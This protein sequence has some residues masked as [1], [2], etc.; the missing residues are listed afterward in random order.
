RA[1]VRAG[2]ALRKLG[3]L[4]EARRSFEDAIA[5]I[6]RLAA[7]A[8]MNPEARG[9]L[10]DSPSAWTGLA[11]TLAKQGNAAG[12]LSAAEARLAHIRRVQLAAFQ[13]D[14]T[15]GETPDEQA[16]EQGVVRDII[17][18][19][20]QLRAERGMAHPDA[21]RLDTLQQQLAR[22]VARRADQQSRLYARLP[23]LQVRRAVRF[24]PADVNALIGDPQTV[25]VEYIIGDDEVLV[26]SARRGDEAVELAAVIVPTPRHDL[27][28]NIARAMQPAALQDEAEW[29]KRAAPIGAVLL[30]PIRDVLRDRH[31]VV[32]VPD[33]LLWKV[34]FEAVPEGDGDLA[35]HRR[36][37]YAT[38]LATLAM[39][40]A[41]TSVQTASPSVIIVA[42]PDIPA[43]VRAQ[44]VLTEPGWKE[45]DSAAVLAAAQ[46]IAARYADKASV[47]TAAD[48]SEAAVRSALASA[49][50]A[51][52][53]APFHVSGA[54]P[55]FSSVLLA[56]TVDQPENDG[57][58]E[59][60]EWFGTDGRARVMI[61]PDGAAFG[62]AGI[63]SAMDV[64]AWAAAS[65]GVSSLVLGRWPSDAFSVE[66][67]TRALHAQLATGASSMD[68]WTT[69][70][71]VVREKARA[72][73][74]WAGLRLIGGGG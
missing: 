74:A 73:A 43:P 46:D 64:L 65:G 56:G 53:A 42:V 18:T 36:V 58:W 8:P 39:E 55:L 44:L 15:R 17:S 61:I 72:P 70:V 63:G 57:R 16:D 23:D 38:S 37:S 50:V 20:A 32:V 27:A 12:A 6:D 62:A 41:L 24:D 1:S 3:R 11:F 60:R 52:I 13:R 67:L 54:A 30:T 45:P 28:D 9:Q 51:H 69:A 5:V 31:H 25:I 22:L 7:E 59:A 33:D 40:R 26:M 29:R 35:S 10:D 21:A 71:G 2:E 49:D 4:D 19:R 68:A 48:A 47:R 34:P 14:I 66:P